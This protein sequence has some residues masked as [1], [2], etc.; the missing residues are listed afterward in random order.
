MTLLAI[1][2]KTNYTDLK[3]FRMTKMA[4][5][6]ERDSYAAELDDH[7]DIIRSEEA[8]SAML[9][10]TAVQAL[11]KIGPYRA[12]DDLVHGKFTSDSIGGIGA[13]L[14]S[15][16]RSPIKRMLFTAGSTIVGNL[17]G[18]AGGEGKGLLGNVMERIGNI[19]RK[20]KHEPDVDEVHVEDPI[21]ISPHQ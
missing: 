7:W 12:V 11:R 21:E 16:T 8:R 13:V 9:K 5:R 18:G 15:L 2:M 1:K 20:D 14:G 17:F 6:R 10:N 19:F 3:T 4:L